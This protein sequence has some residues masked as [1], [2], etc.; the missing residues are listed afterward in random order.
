MHH[1]EPKGKGKECAM[2]GFSLNFPFQ[3]LNFIVRNGIELQPEKGG[4]KQ[5]N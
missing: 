1:Y 5:N 4:E 3:A 2:V